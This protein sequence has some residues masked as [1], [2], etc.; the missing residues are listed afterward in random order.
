MIF[1]F[2]E[3]IMIDGESIVLGLHFD[4]IYSK[5]VL[6]VIIDVDEWV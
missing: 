6:L 2:V 1:L 5:L 3:V 4:Y